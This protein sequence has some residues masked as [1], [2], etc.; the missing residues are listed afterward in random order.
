MSM[1]NEEN[2]RH[3]ESIEARIASLND[4]LDELSESPAIFPALLHPGC[5][6]NLRA[7][8][9]VILP[10]GFRPLEFVGVGKYDLLSPSQPNVENEK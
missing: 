8:D 4:L 3:E 7:S 5:I 6:G 10:V 9:V 1:N 2:C